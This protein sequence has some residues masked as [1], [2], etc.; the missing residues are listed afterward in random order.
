[1]LKYWAFGPNRLATALRVPP[2]KRTE[3]VLTLILLCY[4]I[5][6]QVPGKGYE[7]S[8]ITVEALAVRFVEFCNIY[9]SGV[10]KS[11]ARPKTPLSY[12]ADF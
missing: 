12:G 1:M 7:Y 2:N 8:H 9:H 3:R 4:V 11:K 10:R 6:S 5:F